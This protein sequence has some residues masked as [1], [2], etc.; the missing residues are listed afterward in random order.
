MRLSSALDWCARD[1][2]RLWDTLAL[3][4]EQ[5]IA[6][7]GGSRREQLRAWYANEAGHAPAA[8]VR[9]GAR[10]VCR[11]SGA[12]PSGLRQAP[13][14]PHG[15]WVK[16]GGADR[17]GELLD[18]PL[19]AIVGTGR[20]TDYGHELAHSLGRELSGAGIAVAAPLA[21]GIGHSGL[22]GASQSGES[23]IALLSGGVDECLPRLCAGVYRRLERAGCL[24]SEL[25]CG[26]RSRSWAQL[27]CART[28]ALLAD[29]VIV[30]EA[31]ERPRE[32]ACAELAATLGKK[33]A[34]FPGRATSPASRGTLRLIK[35]G[36]ELVRGAHDALALLYGSPPGSPADRPPER[37]PDSPRGRPPGGPRGRPPD[38]PP[39]SPPG[40]PSGKQPGGAPP[41][42]MPPGGPGLGECS[43]EPRL[44]TTLERVAA[45]EDTIA[46]LG[47]RGAAAQLTTATT[48]ATT[49]PVL[50]DLAE[51]ELRG[52]L[53]RGDGG[54]YIPRAIAP[55]R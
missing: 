47:R 29:M 46:K 23:A 27:A 8:C 15:L 51:L 48:M 26:S 4:D 49:D 25:P 21:T 45:G 13:L 9:A 38:S 37:P 42:D 28:L 11:H 36:A 43:L 53:V 14:A 10:L 1:P 22:A 41:D 34:A 44:K 35:Q 7:L 31:D 17:L 2:Q 6:A 54:R 55:P 5:L 18:G 52:L 32:L 30:V 40:S 33:L 39:D 16:D 24:L 50:L 19:V 20:C 12:Y 3:S